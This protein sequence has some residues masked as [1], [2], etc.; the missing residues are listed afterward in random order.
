[1]YSG[2]YGYK[3]WTDDRGLPGDCTT[4]EMIRVLINSFSLVQYPVLDPN[5][6]SDFGIVSVCVCV[7]VC[8]YVFRFVINPI[9]LF[10][11][12]SICL[13][14]S[15]SLFPSLPP[16]LPL[17]NRAQMTSSV[18]I[19]KDSYLKQYGMES[20]IHLTSLLRWHLTPSGLWRLLWKES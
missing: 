8:V 9:R 10:I 11:C 19:E 4:E 3:W 2:W 12:L 18:I 15:L 17:F 20:Y 6:P 7:C 5:A 1:M 16:S 13:S 14:V